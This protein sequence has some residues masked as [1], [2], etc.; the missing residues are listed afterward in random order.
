MR[1]W[2]LEAELSYDLYQG[3]RNGTARRSFPAEV[4][5]HPQWLLAANALPHAPG[6]IATLV[7]GAL[8]VGVGAD[9]LHVFTVYYL[10]NKADRAASIYGAIGTAVV[11]LLWLFIAARIVVG[12]AVLNA[13]LSRRREVAQQRRRRAPAP[14]DA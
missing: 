7:P 1:R 4:M 12:S 13:E 5:R 6:P 2:A 14:P 11:I 9:A 3:G 10:A 8:L